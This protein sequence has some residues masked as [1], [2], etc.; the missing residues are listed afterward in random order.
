MKNHRIEYNKD[1][2]VVS[3]GDKRITGRS[4]DVEDLDKFKEWINSYT[5][6][7][8]QHDNRELLLNIGRKMFVW[9]NGNQNWLTKCLENPTTSFFIE[10]RYLMDL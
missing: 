7:F 8:K 10:F 5:H 4:A 1:E 9:L 6:A 3:H 2:V